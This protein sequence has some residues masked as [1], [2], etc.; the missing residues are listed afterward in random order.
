MVEQSTTDQEHRIY[1]K[2]LINNLRRHA[3]EMA[4]G[5]YEAIKSFMDLLT[6]YEQ[7][8]T[9]QFSLSHSVQATLSPNERLAVKFATDYGE[10]FNS[11]F[12]WDSLAGLSLE[13][14]Y[15]QRYFREV[16]IVIEAT[17]SPDSRN[18]LHRIVG[19]QLRANEYYHKMI[20]VV[21]MQRIK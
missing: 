12:G 13:H 8:S 3:K 1:G 16:G 6:P 15:V 7:D 18:V 21:A 9:P 4:D 10:S 14:E 20:G 2:N 5:N 11:N 17:L 19:G